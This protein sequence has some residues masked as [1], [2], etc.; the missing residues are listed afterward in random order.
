MR[1]GVRNTENKNEKGVD[2]F[3]EIG[4]NELDGK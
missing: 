1:I 2:N 4:Y 3:W